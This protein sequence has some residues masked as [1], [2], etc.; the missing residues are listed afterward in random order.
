MFEGM[1]LKMSSAMPPLEDD[2][3]LLCHR[4]AD[5]DPISSSYL[6]RLMSE[7]R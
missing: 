5:E 6:P 7:L 1:S 2:A 3:L 4:I